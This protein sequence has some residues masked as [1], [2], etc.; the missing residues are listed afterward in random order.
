MTSPL[1]A[2]LVGV[3]TLALAAAGAALPGVAAAQRSPADIVLGLTADPTEVGPPGGPIALAVSVRNAGGA[4]AVDTTFKLHLPA[5]ATLSF[6]DSLDG[7]TCDAAA[8]KC[9]GGTLAAG[10]LNA[11]QLRVTL[12]AGADGDTATISATAETRSRESSTANNTGQVT[13]RYVAKPDLAFSYDPELVEISYL[14][15]MGARAYVQ[16]RATNVGT[17]AA[18]D[19]RFEFR[20][21]PGAWMDMGSFFPDGNECDL[22][23]PT[24]VCTGGPVAP[25]EFAYLNLAVRFPAGTA[26]DTLTMPGSA[27]TTV[28]ERS[29]TNNTGDVTF[30]YVVPPPADITVNWVSVVPADQVKATQPFDV[31]V[32]LDNIGGRPAED[33]KVRVPLAP[34]VEPVSLDPDFPDWTCAVVDHAVECT[35]AEP[36]DIVQPYN[37]LR[38]Q[39]RAGPGT[40]DGPLTFT[41]SASTS[42]PEISVDN[43]T[44]EGSTT[45]VAEG[46]LTGRAWHDLD[47]DGQR[48]AEEP[49]AYAEIGKIEL[50]LEG[51]QPDSWDTPRAYP[52]D[53]DGSYLARLKPGRYVV[54]VYL[55]TASTVDFTTPDVGDDATDS[56]IVTSIR[57]YWNPRGLSAVVEVRDGAETVVDIGLVPIE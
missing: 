48:E 9:K 34:T 53:R 27:S 44:G 17:V 13:V 10:T 6:G 25:G 30:R 33:V 37:R 19:V 12:P 35:R 21:P 22:S 39:M 52:N 29:L 57:D 28:A 23:G 51:T 36:Y 26:G 42:S 16:A 7:W 47:G 3:A 4:D 55:R 24:W 31:Y 46:L 41:A 14:G 43:N 11:V 40:P 15:G 18:P 45:Y 38:L 32:E 54:Y 50:V 56:D 49:P 2:G 1:R 20:P 8:L 5:G